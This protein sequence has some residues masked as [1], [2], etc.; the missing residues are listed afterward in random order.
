M[1]MVVLLIDSPLSQASC[2]S[3]LLEIFWSTS[4]PSHHRGYYWGMCLK[5]GDLGNLGMETVFDFKSILV[6]HLSSQGIPNMTCVTPS[7][8]P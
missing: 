8:G 6:F 2:L 1:E 7:Q 4:R 5:E 3:N